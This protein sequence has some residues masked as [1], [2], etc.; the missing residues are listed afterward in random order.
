MK[1]DEKCS[2]NS[3]ILQSLKVHEFRMIDDRYSHPKI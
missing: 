2:F 3:D 1:W